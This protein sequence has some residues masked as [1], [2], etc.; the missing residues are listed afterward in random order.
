MEDLGK[1]VHD[2]NL[3]VSGDAAYVVDDH[4]QHLE[5]IAHYHLHG[6]RALSAELKR[7]HHALQVRQS[8]HQSALIP[9]V[10]S[11]LDF[12]NASGPVIGEVNLGDV[13]DYVL[14]GTPISEK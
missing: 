8:R 14:Q 3:V 10:K 11:S 1:E 4:L 7:L 12:A 2:L 9:T 5:E 13:K 6:A